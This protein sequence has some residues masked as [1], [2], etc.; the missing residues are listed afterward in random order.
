MVLPNQPEPATG[1]QLLKE[2]AVASSGQ[3]ARSAGASVSHPAASA[4]RCA[5]L[6]PAPSRSRPV[7]DSFTLYWRDS[8]SRQAALIRLEPLS[9]NRPFL[10]EPPSA[11][12]SA[13]TRVQNLCPKSMSHNPAGHRVPQPSLPWGH[14]LG[15]ARPRFHPDQQAPLPGSP[16]RPAVVRTNLGAP[17]G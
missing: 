11:A 8:R 6:R 1:A 10:R 3:P 2:A 15:Y 4:C 9:Q 5:P 13:G 7:P 12:T 16:R 17:V 14:L